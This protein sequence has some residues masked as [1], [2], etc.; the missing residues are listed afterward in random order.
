MATNYTKYAQLINTSTTYARR[1]KRLSNR[2]FGEVAL[3]TNS[4]SMKVVKI[5]SARPLHTNEEII[6]YY[7][8]HM[9]THKLM[10]NLRDYGLFRD[11]HQDFKEEMKRLRELRGKVKVWRRLLDKKAEAKE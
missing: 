2:I 3:P 9:E 7:P 8:R 10:M 11:E 6:H 5:F 4:K 1:M